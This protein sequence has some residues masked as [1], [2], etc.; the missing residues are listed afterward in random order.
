MDFVFLALGGLI[1]WLISHRYYLK[2]GKELVTEAA[3][4]R[5]L[6]T[7]VLRGMEEANLVEWT[8]D[9]TGRVTG[10]TFHLQAEVGAATIRGHNTIISSD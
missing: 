3:E 9:D 2:S 7:L 6:S 8:K 5:R 10:I 4:L 1:G